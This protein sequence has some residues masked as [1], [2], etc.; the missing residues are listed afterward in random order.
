MVMFVLENASSI[1]ELRQAL[2]EKV[3]TRLLKSPS[4]VMIAVILLGTWA[5][6]MGSRREI[7]T[8][9]S[10][11]L[12]CCLPEVGPAMAPGICSRT[13]LRNWVRMQCLPCGW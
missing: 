6:T 5:H 10:V 11:L 8:F 12:E 1:K 9:S 4:E 3:M 7:E 13:S 2:E